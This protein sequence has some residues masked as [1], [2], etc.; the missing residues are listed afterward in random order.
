MA[1]HGY[2][3][4]PPGVRCRCVHLY[5]DG[6]DY[7]CCNGNAEPIQIEDAVTNRF[8]RSIRQLA[9]ARRK[10][11]EAQ[12]AMIEAEREHNEASNAYTDKFFREQPETT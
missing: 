8:D 10:F 7:Y 3:I 12:T 11:A 9:G 1:S 4:L 2:R 5:K 6:D